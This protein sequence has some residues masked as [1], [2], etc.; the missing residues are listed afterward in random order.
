[1]T[2]GTTSLDDAS[3]VLSKL[4]IAAYEVNLVALEQ[5]AILGAR[6]PGDVF[7]DRALRA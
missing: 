7:R 4:I 3:L 2:L 6:Q 1:V 5:T